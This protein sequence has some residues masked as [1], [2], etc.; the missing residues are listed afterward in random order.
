[1]TDRS[2]TD[3]QIRAAFE[4]RTTGSSSPELAERIAAE[5]RATR[6][7]P[8]L[9][10]IPGGLGRNS[11]R[12]L[13]A[14]AISATSLA[15]IG[16][17]LFAGRQPDEQTSVLPSPAPTAT[18][19]EPVVSPSIPA[20]STSSP[21]PTPAVQPT[22]GASEP[23]AVDPGLGVDSP[24]VTL[25]GD[26][27]VRS[28]PTVD[29]SSAKLEPLLPAGVRL[30][31]IAESVAADGYAWY[32][33]IPVDPGYPSGWV[34]AGIREGDPW[35]TSAQLDCPELPVAAANL[36]SLGVYG[37]LACY[38]KREIEVTGEM[39]CDVGDVD[40]SIGGPSWLRDDRHCTLDLGDSTM[41]VLDG[42][43]PIDYGPG[44]M[45]GIVTGHFAD[46]E[47]STCVSAIEDVD[48]P[49][50]ADEIVATCRAMFVGTDWKSVPID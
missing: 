38:G 17:L 36:S 20:E 28:K 37:G 4:A 50:D 31:V 33:V 40:L 11:Q 6:Q 48:P 19:S 44:R 16:G 43:M 27:R 35:I 47:S 8:R 45:N 41:E 39:T 1:M 49:P 34:A 14:A 30:L 26:L 15:L 13:W 29:V 46:P 24:A 7:Q 3:I 32:H 9:Q 22:P 25:V 10:L 5:T 21:A 18:P 23:P 12:L 42:G 2:L